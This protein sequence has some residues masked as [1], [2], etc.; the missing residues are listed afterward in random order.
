[1]GIVRI[2]G[3]M[4]LKNSFRDYCLYINLNCI[5]KSLVIFNK[6]SHKG[7][8]CPLWLKEDQRGQHCWVPTLF[9]TCLRCMASGGD[10]SAVAACVSRRPRASKC[11]VKVGS[12]TAR[13]KTPAFQSTIGLSWFRPRSSGRYRRFST[14]IVDDLTLSS[15]RPTPS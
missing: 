14:K 4:V 7:V 12:R 13:W 15:Q 2:M 9:K 3:S 10:I 5:S 6:S 8:V 11:L 1:M